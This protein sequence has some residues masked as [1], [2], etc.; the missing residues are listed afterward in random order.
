MGES[1]FELLLNQGLVRDLCSA[2]GCREDVYF[3][4][5]LC[6]RHIAEGGAQESVAAVSTWMLESREVSEQEVLSAAVR[7]GMELEEA[8]EQLAEELYIAPDAAVASEEELTREVGCSRRS[9]D[10]RYPP[11]S[12]MI[13]QRCGSY[14]RGLPGRGPLPCAAGRGGRA[15][16]LPYRSGYTRE[17][18]PQLPP[19]SE[20]DTRQG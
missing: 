10:A 3:P 1:R 2:P 8:A 9:T 20:R 15:G 18:W 17:A 5:N 11:G 4:L 12:V 7:A 13:L 19:L 16:L 6:S 14:A